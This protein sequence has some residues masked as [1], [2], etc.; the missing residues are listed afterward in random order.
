MKKKSKQEWDDYLQ[1]NKIF[2]YK[3]RIY[4]VSKFEFNTMFNILGPRFILNNTDI[5]LYDPI[6]NKRIWFKSKKINIGETTMKD[7]YKYCERDLDN[8]QKQYNKGDVD[9]NPATCNSYSLK[10]IGGYKEE[11]DD[12]MSEHIY[13]VEIE[14]DKITREN[15][16][17]EIENKTIKA[18][19]NVFIIIGLYNHP[20]IGAPL[21]IQRSIRE[22]NC[23]V[24]LKKRP[25]VLYYDC[26]HISTCTKCENEGNITKCPICRTEVKNDK[27][28]L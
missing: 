20:D 5:D 28:Q 21:P 8:F 26:R 6:P 24:C 7:I 14:D 23:C 13:Y 1:R 25:N 17:F 18:P 9:G 15:K 16:Y 19:F 22:K 3:I 2:S 10:V 11:I 12:L 4:E 27:I